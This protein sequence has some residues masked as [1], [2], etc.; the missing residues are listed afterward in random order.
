SAPMHTSRH[1]PTR[2]RPSS[3]RPPAHEP[4]GE[5]YVVTSNEVT[6]QAEDAPRRRTRTVQPVPHATV[7][8]RAARGKAARKLVPRESHAFWEPKAD[9]PDP[10]GLL[11]EQEATRVPE[12]VPIRHQRMLVSPFTFYRGSAIVMATDLA[13]T[14]ATGIKV[15]LCGDA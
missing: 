14:P 9:R 8:E 1:S 5:E 7:E 3:T 4:A 2:S 15:Q 11:V 12:L 13:T 10:V 6:E